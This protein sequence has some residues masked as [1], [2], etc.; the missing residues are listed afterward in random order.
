LLRPTTSEGA[1]AIS[2]ASK[3][4]W[5]GT[6]GDSHAFLK[7]FITRRITPILVAFGIPDAVRGAAWSSDISTL[8]TANPLNFHIAFAAEPFAVTSIPLL[9]YRALGRIGGPSEGRS[10]KDFLL[11]QLR[12]VHVTYLRNR[13]LLLI[14]QRAALD[15][16]LRI[17]ALQALHRDLICTPWSFVGHVTPPVSCHPAPILTTAGEAVERCHDQP[18]CSD[19]AGKKRSNQQPAVLHWWALLTH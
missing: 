5:I 10:M 19:L 7:A 16:A 1:P 12:L 18:D 15:S 2:R 6:A 17:L 14:R 8:R 9:K 11:C 4:V 13:S 3:P